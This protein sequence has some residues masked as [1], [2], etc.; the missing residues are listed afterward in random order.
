MDNEKA[1]AEMKKIFEEVKE[2][3]KK[4]DS[5]NLHDFS[6]DNNPEKLYGRKYQ[7]TKCGGVVDS[8]TKSWYESG[9]AHG[10]KSINKDV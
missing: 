3:H 10:I 7:C 5:C 1:K 6:I 2:N 4:L 8:V 9:V